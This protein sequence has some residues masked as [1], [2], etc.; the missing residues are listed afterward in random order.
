MPLLLCGP[1]LS[2][3]LELTSSVR[4]VDVTPTLLELAGSTIPGNMD[5]MSLV[6]IARGDS[7]AA[8]TQPVFAVSKP[9][10]HDPLRVAAYRWPWKYILTEQLA[11]GCVSEQEIYDL[12]QDP[13]ET[14]NLVSYHG[15]LCSGFRTLCAGWLGK[16]LPEVAPSTDG[17]S[18]EELGR[19]EALGYVSP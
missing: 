10:R 13:R 3:G 18:D 14:T 2:R 12:S 4:L 9:A 19:L 8:D 6:G 11:R 16:K 17:L 1:G 15:E 7:V 5:G